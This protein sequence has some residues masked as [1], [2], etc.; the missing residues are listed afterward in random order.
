MNVTEAIHTRKATRAML[1]T[2]ISE[3]TIK[4]LIELAG[5]TPSWGNSQPWEVYV[6]TGEKLANLKMRWRKE[7][8]QGIPPARPDISAPGHKDWD[9]VPR[10]RES[11][12]QW[13]KHRL[14]E[15]NISSEQ[16]DKYSMD[17]MLDFYHAP[18][19]IYLGLHQSHGA[20]SF[21]DIGAYGQTL[22]LAA[23][24]RGIQSIPAFSFVYFGDILHEEL[25]IPESISLFMGVCLGYADDSHSMNK[26]NSERI[27]SE[28]FCSWV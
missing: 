8:S 15:M 4:E 7:F 19:C 5:R 25:N 21:Y 6:V 17:L 11:I 24:E 14:E 18:V 12:L 2:P 26:P 13:K 1:S 20:Y 22:M 16:Y 9:K 10:C 3:V 27:G 23:T 28:Q